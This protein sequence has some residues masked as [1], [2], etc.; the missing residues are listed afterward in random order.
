MRLLL[1]TSLALFVVAPAQAV[2]A[3]AHAGHTTD[4]TTDHTTGHT[5]GNPPAHGAR[6]GLVADISTLVAGLGQAPRAAEP[7]VGL[8]FGD[9][10]VPSS[11]ADAHLLG[12]GSWA[13]YDQRADVPPGGQQY[14]VQNSALSMAGY[15]SAMAE[16][17]G[18][19]VVAA[20]VLTLLGLLGLRRRTR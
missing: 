13:A 6:E 4:H 7:A 20:A 8:S 5:T 14:P 18:W 10:A 16:P 15:S 12:A 17:A 11:P 2:A 9:G 3:H 19:A 1:L